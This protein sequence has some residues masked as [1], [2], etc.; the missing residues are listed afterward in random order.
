MAY[1]VNPPSSKR[2]GN[3]FVKRSMRTLRRLLQNGDKTLFTDY[4]VAFNYYL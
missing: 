3:R 4:T 2:A 1:V